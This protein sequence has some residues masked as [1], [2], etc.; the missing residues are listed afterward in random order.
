[1]DQRQQLGQQPTGN[2]AQPP[3]TPNPHGMTQMN[4]GQQGMGAQGQGVASQLM[5][6]MTMMSN[7]TLAT[8][9]AGSQVFP[10]PS[11]LSNP[12]AFFT[13]PNQNGNYNVATMQQMATR[14]PANNG[15][16]NHHGQHSIQMNIQGIPML[17]NGSTPNAQHGIVPV[18]VG[19]GVV[20][21][22]MTTSSNVVGNGYPG[23][24]QPGQHS[25]Q[26]NHMHVQPSII[27]YNGMPQNAPASMQMHIAAAAPVPAF[28]Q[29][30]TNGQDGKGTKRK[31][32][33]SANDK[34]RQN[35]DR[36]REHA[37][38]TRLRK[39]AYVQKLTELVEG[40]HAERTEELRQRRVA[41]QHLSETQNVR[42][43]VIRSFLQFN[44]K[45]ERDK[46]KWSAILE[47]DVW[48]KQPVTPY[49]CYRRGELEQVRLSSAHHKILKC[50]YPF[51]CSSSHHFSLILTFYS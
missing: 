1:M 45:Y 17:Q 29:G 10:N 37:K 14:L 34:A 33:L 13:M 16:G 12:S 36:N 42:R 31:K 46:R 9:A 11:M 49:R 48:V 41:I 44:S 7:P 50:N 18:S 20:I 51:I 43:A 23:M 27:S 8:A 15:N 35:R 2:S 26:I 40:L 28:V 39:K 30:D 3:I 25:I 47:D 24:Q 6:F 5:D 38:T 32:D 19:S 22:Q 21:P 4:N